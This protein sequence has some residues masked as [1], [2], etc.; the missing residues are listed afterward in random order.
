MIT[1][2]RKIELTPETILQR[3]SAYDIF[4]FYMGAQKWKINEATNSVFHKDDN[5]SL[6]IGNRNGFLHF[7]DFSLPDIKGDAFSFVKFLYKLDSMDDVLKLIDKEFGLGISCTENLGKYEQITK[8]YKQPE[9]ELGKRYS[10]IQCITR[11][12][13]K[14]ELDWWAEYYQTIDDLRANHIYSI[15]KVY[16]NRRLFPL[17]ED[18]LRFG[19]LYGNSWKIYRPHSSKKNKW[20]PNN[21]P[22]ITTY[23]ME[24]LNK[25]H[26]TLICKSMKDYLVCHKIYP[27]VMHV[28]NESIS[29]Y[30][31]ETISYIKE[32]SKEVY[33]G[34]D[35][36]EVGKA[37]SYLLTSTF[38]WK[39]INTPDR[40][41]PEINDWAGWARKEGLEAVA[42]HFIT[43]KLIP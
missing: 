22:L 28:Q 9:I 30:S 26:N 16:L 8:S 29:S 17:K 39:H 18:E 24:N 14:E 5:P 1:G 12:F 2:K 3:I 27:Y 33:Y 19:Y 23:G 31:N 6:L 32:N 42:R 13:T 4:R 10:V 36:D 38:G 25:E 37:T 21:V 20:I 41:L 35:S 34:G 7:I 43:K 11:K 40:L 15:D